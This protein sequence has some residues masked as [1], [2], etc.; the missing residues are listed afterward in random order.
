MEVGWW[1][2]GHWE[3]WG[4]VGRGGEGWDWGLGT[5][6]IYIDKKIIRLICLDDGENLRC[7]AQFLYVGNCLHQSSNLALIVSMAC[8]VEITKVGWS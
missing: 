1:E 2:G 6:L 8:T 3:G 5:W 4:G 7:V